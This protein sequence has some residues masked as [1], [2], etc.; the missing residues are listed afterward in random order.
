MKRWSEEKIHNKLASKL[1]RFPSSLLSSSFLRRE[2]RVMK[3]LEN[4]KLF[5]TFLQFSQ[6]QWEEMTG[7]SRMFLK[8]KGEEDERK[9][10]SAGWKLKKDFHLYLSWEI[11]LKKKNCGEL[12]GSKK[13]EK[14]IY[15]QHHEE[16]EN[17]SKI[18]FPSLPFIAL[19]QKSGD[20]AFESC[21]LND[22]AIHTVYKETTSDTN[23]SQY[24]EEDAGEWRKVE[25]LSRAKESTQSKNY[26]ANKRWITTDE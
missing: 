16:S 7:W 19:K 17:E 11:L 26:L 2:E 1:V 21:S 25:T 10:F 15:S 12:W 8:S 6:Q 24:D 9:S 23:N 14:L 5:K 22:A 4:G 13:K 20:F 3:N 18:D